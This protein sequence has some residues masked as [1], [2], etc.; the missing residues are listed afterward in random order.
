MPALVRSLL[1]G[2]TRRERARGLRSAIPTGTALRDLR[3]ARQIVT[4]DLA[5]RFA[6][7][8]DDASLGSRVG[9]LV[10]T[11]RAVPGR[12]RRA[13]PDRGRRPD[14]PLPGLRPAPRG[15]RAARRPARAEPAG[16]A[17]APRRPRLHGA[18]RRHRAPGR[19]DV[20]GRARVRE[21]ARAAPRRRPRRPRS[22]ASSCAPRGRSRRSAAPGA[23]S[24]SSS[25]ARSRSRS[26]RTA[27]SACSTSRRAP[28]ADADRVVP[29]LPQ[30]AHVVVGAVLD[31]DAV[32]DATSPA[33][34]RCTSTGRCRRTRPPTAASG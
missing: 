22:P 18:E 21:V 17:A 2:P 4:V 3:I 11:L 19:R 9:Q 29:R 6:S 32:G 26:S 23:A 16:D 1:A 25:A 5:A 15:P 13:R 8:R 14:R 34:S 31:V 7:G 28:A 30:G 20:D 10:R 27:S 24:R 12:P 33:G